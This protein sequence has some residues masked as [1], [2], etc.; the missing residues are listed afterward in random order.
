MQPVYNAHV[1]DKLSYCLAV[2]QSCNGFW[3]RWPNPEAIY[4]FKITTGF[5]GTYC[6]RPMAS[7]QAPANLPYFDRVRN[8][9]KKFQWSGL[10][11]TQPITT[12]FLT[13]HDSVTLVKCTKFPC[14]QPNV[15]NKAI[16]FDWISNSIELAGSRLIRFPLN[17]YDIMMYVMFCWN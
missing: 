5:P 1:I 14:D 2:H 7:G 8:S 9:I 10:K 4:P 12:E 13:H 6:L 17:L 11:C 15:M 16:T 3:G